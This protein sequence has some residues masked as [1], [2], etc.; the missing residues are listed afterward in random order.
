MAEIDGTSF[1][2][3]QKNTSKALTRVMILHPVACGLAF[4]AFLMALGAGF[5][6][7][8]FAAMTALCA[9][10]V[11]VVVLACDFTVFGIIKKHINGSDDDSG[12]H[13]VFGAGM[14]T[15]L[16]AMI[17]LLIG[18]LFVLLTCCSSR[19]HHQN[20]HGNSKVMDAGYGAGTRTTPRRRFWQR[21]NRF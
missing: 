5:C 13:A 8:I 12:S 18:T 1:N 19:M 4:I 6:G 9:W 20:K 11:T 21:R 7:A 17:L 3:A 14:W 10:L 16:A 2:T 15:L